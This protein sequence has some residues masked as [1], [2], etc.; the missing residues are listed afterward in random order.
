MITHKPVRRVLAAAFCT[1][2]MTPAPAPV[3]CAGDTSKQ[4][5]ELS[6]RTSKASEDVDKYV[7]QLDKTEQALSSVSQ[8]QSKDLKKRYDSFSREIDGLEETQKEA[9]S[10]IEQMKSAGTEYFKTWDTSIAQMSNP[11]LKQVSTE[12]RSKIMK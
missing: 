10:D 8:A 2:V 5:A 6:K 9:T 12:R 11:E 7:A 4:S 1:V 3:G